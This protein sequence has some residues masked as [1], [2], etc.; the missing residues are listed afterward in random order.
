ML[1]YLLNLGSG[2]GGGTI[3]RPTGDYGSSVFYAPAPVDTSNLQRFILEEL[4]KIAA[5][6]SL[7]SAG[8]I[9]CSYAS[10]VRLIDG[11]IRY[12]DGTG[13]NPGSGKGMYVY[14]GAAWHLLG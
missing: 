12:A 4:N 9:D 11:D 5:A 6:I 8:H 7:L 10:P 13:W 14:R 2:G 3:T 1:L